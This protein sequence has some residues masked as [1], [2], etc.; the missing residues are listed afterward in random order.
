MEDLPEEKRRRQALTWALALTENTP[1][2]LAEQA[3]LERYGCGELSLDQ[4]L[5]LLE[6]PVHQVLYR[7][8]ATT[9]LRD[10]QL[11][12]LLEQAA[13]FNKKHDLTGLLCY[14]D[15][16]FIQLLEGSQQAVHT[17]YAKIRR[18]ARHQHVVTLQ[19]ASAPL[20]FF[21]DWRLAFVRSDPLE[22]Y[23]LITHLEARHQHLVLPQI[24]ITHP[25]LLTLLAAFQA[26]AQ[27]SR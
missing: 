22:M 8:Q 26:R 12:D 25:H 19:D 1:M 27:P 24:P 10:D 20:R 2:A 14:G 23:W 4:L 16:R 5:G 7:S 9:P 11:T 18:D 6:R 3:L 15:G 13:A 21:S 17:L